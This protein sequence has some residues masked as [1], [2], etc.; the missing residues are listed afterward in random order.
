MKSREPMAERVE[1]APDLRYL[2]RF[3]G[4]RAFDANAP[5]TSEIE[6][7]FS[8]IAALATVASNARQSGDESTAMEH[9][10]NAIALASAALEINSFAEGDL[11]RR[12]VAG[13]MMCLALSCGEADAARSHMT[14]LE[15]LSGPTAEIDGWA[16]LRDIELWPDAWLVAAIR[17]DPP[18]GESLE[19]LAARYWRPLF[20]RCEML[21]LHREKAADLAQE[22]WRR[23]LRN[24]HA[25]KPGGNFPAYLHRVAT[26]IWRDGHRASRRA[27]NMAEDRLASLNAPISLEDGTAFSLGDAIPDLRSMDAEQQRSLMA[28]IDHALGLL[29]PHLREV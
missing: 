8:R 17:R 11:A 4:A 2:E 15:R 25:L 29:A 23:V 10:R 14:G 7:L 3:C 27:G 22:A 26:N 1:G 28:D 6:A 9:F 24:R 21:T 5:A 12:R 18:D 19:A 20:G 13:V 16:E